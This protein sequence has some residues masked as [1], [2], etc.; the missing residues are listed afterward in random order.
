MSGLK[1]ILGKARENSLL[2]L[3]VISISPHTSKFKGFPSR[4]QR[5]LRLRQFLK[6]FCFP[7][8]FLYIK[9]E[10]LEPFLSTCHE[11][12][13][14]LSHQPSFY[15]SAHRAHPKYLLTALVLSVLHHHNQLWLKTDPGLEFYP[16]CTESSKLIPQPFC[17]NFSG[18]TSI[19]LA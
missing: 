18:C 15:S 16:F 13:S 9:R 4:K 10:P 7:R 17:W 19:M 5:L 2:K 1:L 3:L 14:M 8:F 11:Q 12:L 6:A